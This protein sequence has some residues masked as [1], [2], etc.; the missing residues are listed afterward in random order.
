LLNIA[1]RNTTLQF[2]IAGPV[3]SDEIKEL[4]SDELRPANVKYLGVLSR[5]EVVGLLNTSA[6]GLVLLH[7]TPAYLVSLPV[8]MFEYMAAGLP[9]ICSNFDYWKEMAQDCA[10][11]VDPLNLDEIEAAI[12]WMTNNP[13]SAATMGEKG[14]QKVRTELN[15]ENESKKLISFYEDLLQ[16]A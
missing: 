1:R 9:I 7:P 12:L 13:I 11:Y 4:L 5:S 10:I 14:R 8:K 3:N 15:W 6:C 2:K 16:K